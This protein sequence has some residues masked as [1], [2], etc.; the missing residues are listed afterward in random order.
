[1]SGRGT[2][3]STERRKAGPRA[4]GK[5]GV[6]RWI[7]DVFF[8]FGE[9]VVFGFPA[10]LSLLSA[11]FNAEM[12]F[13]ALVAIAALSL[14]VGTVRW[15]EV[16][17]WPATSYRLVPLRIVYH[18]L[19]ILAAAGGGAAVDLFAGSMLGSLVAAAGISV[20]AVW[21]FPRLVGKL[22]RVPPWWQWGR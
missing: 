22:E 15:S 12:K 4:T 21:L 3:G 14:A 11:P 7:E 19:A 16:P 2:D 9:V 5:A 20:V 8:G 1:M 13:A 6:E 17:G 10:L 18:S